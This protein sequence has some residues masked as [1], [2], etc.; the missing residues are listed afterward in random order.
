MDVQ[1]IYIFRWMKNGSPFYQFGE[2]V[3]VAE[4]KY[5][6][7]PPNMIQSLP[8]AL[9]LVQRKY[10][11]MSVVMLTMGLTEAESK[12]LTD[13]VKG[14][15]FIKAVKDVTRPYG[16][17]LDGSPLRVFIIGNARDAIREIKNALV[18]EHFEIMGLGK[19]DDPTLRT[20]YRMNRNLD[21]ILIE[22][23]A[24]SMPT[25]FI[26]KIRDLNKTMMIVTFSPA[27][28][29]VPPPSLNVKGH[30]A[31]PFNKDSIADSLQKMGD[32]RR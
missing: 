27:G 31:P 1:I 30:F 25:D 18:R 2:L 16:K 15:T 28:D 7:K 24:A 6:P 32:Y 8:S 12:Q 3:K 22:V 9:M 13:F 14:V 21:M 17:R 19:L 26:G 4:N 23:S 11:N 29:A 10:Q 5:I 20:I